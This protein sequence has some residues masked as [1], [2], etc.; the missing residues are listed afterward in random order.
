MSSPVLENILLFPNPDVPDLGCFVRRKHG[1]E[2]NEF[3]RNIHTEL[4]PS[5]DFHPSHHQLYFRVQCSHAGHFQ[6]ALVKMTTDLSI[7]G[8]L[9][10]NFPPDFVLGGDFHPQPTNW[11]KFPTQSGERFYWFF[12]QHRDPAGGAWQSDKLNGHSYDIYENGTL[13]TIK[14]DDTGGDKDFDDL[15]IEAAVVG[16]R[17][18]RDIL[19]AVDQARITEL[20]TKE[21]LGGVRERRYDPNADDSKAD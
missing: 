12:G 8:P 13:S 15:V 14:Y 19:Q 16:R 11:F 6:R 10:E 4:N 5:V 3:E 20:V 18:W 1:F 2:S 17:S 9:L 21:G 7:P